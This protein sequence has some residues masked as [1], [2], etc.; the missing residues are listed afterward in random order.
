M[1]FARNYHR[2]ILS[3]FFPYL[4]ATVAEVGAGIGNFSALLLET[5]LTRLIVYEPSPNMFPALSMALAREP[6]VLAVN[7]FFG[8]GEMANFDAVV[9]VNVLEHVEDDHAELARAFDRLRS[10][11]H[12]LLFVPALSWLY[13]DLDRRL[14]HFRRYSRVGLR[15]L[16]HA[17]GFAV[18]KSHY[19]D[20]AG[21]LPWYVNFVLLHNELG[22]RS[23]ALYDRIVVPIMRAIEK[24]VQPPIGKNV[25]LVARKP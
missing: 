14:G 17:S 2:W 11:G 16:A 9:Y 18:V 12:L 20:F 7:D 19:F 23:V 13:S 4:G 24:R 3:E 10:G 8:T 21:I 22:G 15:D 1:S 5:P 25:L 6:R